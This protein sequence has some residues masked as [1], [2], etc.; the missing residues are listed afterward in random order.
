MSRP[1][2]VKGDD[3]VPLTSTVNC[4]SARLTHL[5]GTIIRLLQ[6]LA[7]C[8]VSHKDVYRWTGHHFL[9]RLVA[10]WDSF[11]LLH[12]CFELSNIVC[13]VNSVIAFGGVKE[14]AR[15]MQGG[16]I[17]QL[18]GHAMIVVLQWSTNAK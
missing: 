11:Q 2:V 15:K 18:C 1:A 13:W 10:D 6:W 16:A 8:A 17:H 9:L 3:I 14:F 7:N 5:I 12:G 4:L